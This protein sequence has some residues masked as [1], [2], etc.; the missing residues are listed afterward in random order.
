MSTDT[1]T[2][3]LDLK[4]VAP[5]SWCCIDCD[6]NTA[7]G[8]STRAELQKAFYA[9]ELE[10]GIKQ[11]IDDKSEVYTVRNAVWKAAG[12]EPWGG[13]LCIGCLEKRYGRKLRPKDFAR[14]HPFNV[15]F[16]TPR[17]M[18]RRKWWAGESLANPRE[19]TARQHEMC[20]G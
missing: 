15:L 7:P 10:Q 5:E 14:A 16:G 1:E 4:G 3:K 13:C 2:G 11:T 12:M 19:A 17:L 8:M 6:I 18:R 9:G 20:N